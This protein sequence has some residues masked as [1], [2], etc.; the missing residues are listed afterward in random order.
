M[1]YSTRLL[2][3]AFTI[4]LCSWLHLQFATTRLTAEPRSVTPEMLD[5]AAL[6]DV[7]FFD[8]DRGWAV[9]DRGAIWTTFDGGRE[10]YPQSSGITCQLNAISFLD[11]NN[12]WV[13]GGWS[14]AYSHRTTGI[15]LQTRDG[16][17]T[18]KQVPK[19]ML[20]LLKGI[21]FLSKSEGWAFGQPSALY[22]S[23]VF[24][25][26]D[27]GRSW[28]GVPSDDGTNYVSADFID[29]QHG[30][31]ARQDGG[32]AIADG[33]SIQRAIAP[34]S[35]LQQVHCL[36]F[37]SPT[38]AWAVGDGGLVLQ[39]HDGG[40]SWRS[41][42]TS[43]PEE[44]DEYLDFRAIAIYKNH[45][46]IAGSPGSIVL[47]TDDDGKTWTRLATDHNLPLCSL[48]F[49]DNNRG[50]AVGELGNILATRDGG[51]TWRIQKSGGQRSSLLGIFSDFKS[52][53]LELLVKEA[54]NDGYLT[55]IELLGRHGIEFSGKPNVDHSHRAKESVV[56]TGASFSSTAW[57]FPLRQDGLSIS[58][59]SLV[60]VWDQLHHGSSLTRCEEYV[61]RKIRQWRPEVVVTDSSEFTTSLSHLTNRIVL[62]ALDKSVDPNAYPEQLAQTG[63]RPWRVKRT[64]TVVGNKSTATIQLVTTSLAPRLGRS[65]ADIAGESRAISLDQPL[66]IPTI[67][68]FRLQAS[69]LPNSLGGREFFS[70]LAIQPGRGARRKLGPSLAARLDILKKMAQKRRNIEQLVKF[71]DESTDNAAW[72]AQFNDLTVGMDADDAASVLYEL[73]EEYRKHGRPNRAAQVYH[74]LV[75][76]YS[77]SALSEKVLVRLVQY[78]ASEEIAYI[79]RGKEHI[80]TS[81]AVANHQGESTALQGDLIPTDED[82]KAD[83]NR[84]PEQAEDPGAS[85]LFKLASQIERLRPSVFAEPSLRFPLAAAYRKSGSNREAEKIYQTLTQSRVSD[86]W[87]SCAAAELWLDNSDERPPKLLC[88]CKTNSSKPLLDGKLD[89]DVW[90]A[91]H[92]LSLTSDLHDDREWPA[93]ALLVRD[94]EFLYFAASCRKCN[95]VDYPVSGQPRPRDADLHEQDRVELLI[96]TD[97]DWATYYRLVVDHRGWTGESVNDDTSWNPEWFV[98]HSS[99]Q[100]TWTIEA[101]IPIGELTDAELTPDTAWAIGV[102]RTVPGRGFQSWSKPAAVEPYSQGFGLLIFE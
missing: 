80:D 43:P 86:D 50:W 63:L 30:A 25:T 101:A 17:R 102:Q 70:G 53:P 9:G 7:F 93:I 15:V 69:D 39:S 46:W 20:P 29:S 75:Q 74:A 16:G 32:F 10:W 100:D 68:G 78:Y 87:A 76:R 22:P 85:R 35:G 99:D 59:D 62:S 92:H 95:Q 73:A 71:D 64:F 26:E 37:A 55:A 48:T 47:H 52:V 94:E 51:R 40:K 96:D 83:G 91:A 57:Q 60:A 24:R 65:L 56:A 42:R 14:Q 44:T 2:K 61:V 54:G 49:L 1:L 3:A 33:T 82:K 31:L 45:C 97:R 8:A 81:V 89:D 72:L 11:E 58:A 79:N 88:R 36:K 23:G 18:W 90:K 77:N 5:D 6:H 4:A 84:A 98:A 28:N 34:R 67:Q 13:A 21:K 27:A 38:V 12:G 66:E 41:L 19:L